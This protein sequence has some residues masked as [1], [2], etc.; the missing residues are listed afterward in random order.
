[1]RCRKMEDVDTWHAMKS[2]TNRCDSREQT[3]GETYK[4]RHTFVF[5]LNSD[6]NGIPARIP[7]GLKYITNAIRHFPAV[8]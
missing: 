4:R 6:R 2:L 3:W 5:Y 7:E 1:M 8:K